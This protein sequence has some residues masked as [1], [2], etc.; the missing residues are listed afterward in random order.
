MKSLQSFCQE[1]LKVWTKKRRFLSMKLF[2]ALSVL[3][4]L[5]SVLD[6]AQARAIDHYDYDL[7]SYV[8]SYQ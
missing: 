6:V 7:V 2:I 5:A 1:T 4:V 3:I 8:Y